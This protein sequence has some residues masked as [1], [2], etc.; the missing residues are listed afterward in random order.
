M[1]TSQY[2]ETLKTCAACPKMCAYL[3]PSFQYRRDEREHHTGASRLALQDIQLARE[4]IYHCSGCEECLKVCDLKVPVLERLFKERALLWQQG[5]QSEP[6]AQMTQ[7]LVETGH[8]FHKKKALLERGGSVLLSDCLTEHK[9]PHLFAALEKKLQRKLP[10]T[11][12]QPGFCCGFFLLAAGA[13]EAFKSYARRQADFL[14]SFDTIYSTTS[15]CAFCLKVLYSE[16]AGIDLS[17][18]VRDLF[19]LWL[20]Q[21]DFLIH[22][23]CYAKKA[24]PL[25]SCDSRLNCSGSGAFSLLLD[26]LYAEGRARDW[27]YS[28]QGK[29]LITDCVATKIALRG[30]PNIFFYLEL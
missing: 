7:Q 21:K 30:T 10:A 20:P 15:E 2:R 8:P 28:F 24:F 9:L 27:A 3:C 22:R 5:V 11:R 29:R 4:S 6:L 1:K 18:K 14:L 26:P 12:W 17:E 19:P 16:K 13:E 25:A 23:S